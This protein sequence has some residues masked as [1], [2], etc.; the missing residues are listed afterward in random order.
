ML[1][2]AT[3]TLT[4]DVANQYISHLVYALKYFQ[5]IAP[6][7]IIRTNATHKMYQAYKRDFQEHVQ[8]RDICTIPMTFPLLTES[9]TAARQLFNGLLHLAVPAALSCAYACSFRPGEYL[10]Q[11][12]TI[13]WPYLA[14]A[15]HTYGWFKLTAYRADESSSWPSGYPDV[16]TLTKESRKRRVGRA[17]PFVIYPNPDRQHPLCI[18]Q[19]L[20][21]YIRA[22]NLRPDDPLFINEKHHCLDYDTVRAPVAAVA[23]K[24]GLD[25]KRMSLQC[26][27]YGV[28]VQLPETI[29]EFVRL[30]QGGWS[31]SQAQRHYWLQLFEHGKAVQ[32][33]VYDTKGIPSELIENLYSTSSSPGSLSKAKPK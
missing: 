17:G 20:T 4:P 12:G 14:T 16:I 15:A 30:N 3:P 19:I 21:D 5:L 6:D 9:V 23:R 31:S 13:A 27:R 26:L 10:R 24:H 33:S 32:P 29:P 22:A 2:D 1:E 7:A 18:V 28:N 11:H 8:E 25:P